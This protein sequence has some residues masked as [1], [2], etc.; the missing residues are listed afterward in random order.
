MV[1]PNKTL[2][3]TIHQS[4]TII[5]TLLAI[6]ASVGVYAASKANQADLDL[7]VVRHTEDIKKIQIMFY[8][9]KLT[10]I[11]LKP[12]KSAYDLDLLKHYSNELTSVK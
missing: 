12:D 5:G 2:M 8:K 9:S 10:E 4:A 6:I 3:E 7:L 1:H 11:Q